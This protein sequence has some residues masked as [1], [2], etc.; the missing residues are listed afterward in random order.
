[1]YRKS[2]FKKLCSPCSVRTVARMMPT[3]VI[4]TIAWKWGLVL[5]RI[6]T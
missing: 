6:W 2:R 1:M 3:A 4:G 5:S